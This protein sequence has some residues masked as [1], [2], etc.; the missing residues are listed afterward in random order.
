MKC[1]V[2]GV[3]RRGRRPIA[4]SAA[5]AAREARGWPSTA[6]VELHARVTR[7]EQSPRRQR[8]TQAGGKLRRGRPIL[9]RQRE[10][11][12]RVQVGQG[13]QTAGIAAGLP[14]RVAA[15]KLVATPTRR[16][17]VRR[18]AA[19]HDEQFHQQHVAAVAVR[20]G[21]RGT[22]APGGRGGQV[23]RAIALG[24]VGASLGHRDGLRSLRPPG[25][26]RR[27]SRSGTRPVDRAGPRGRS[28]CCSATSRRERCPPARAPTGREPDRA[29]NANE[30][31]RGREANCR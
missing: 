26:R 20:I 2:A 10:E 9:F 25:P 11:G 14:G 12:R 17:I 6:G 23:R 4:G 29:R 7:R 1:S 8:Q 16:G 22:I 28:R 31:P 27:R 19:V 15:L 24:A 30:S 21:R 5:R 3:G 13:P 18:Q